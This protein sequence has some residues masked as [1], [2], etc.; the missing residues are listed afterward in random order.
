MELKVRK[1]QKVSGKKV[2]EI[3]QRRTLKLGWDF[4][5]TGSAPISWSNQRIKN[6]VEDISPDD[7]Y[8]LI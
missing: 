3:W 6:S 5:R 4:L 8:I 1:I 2:F 7:S